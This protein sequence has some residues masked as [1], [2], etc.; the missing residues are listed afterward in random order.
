MELKLKDG[1][2][3]Y[4]FS[5]VFAGL[6][7]EILGLSLIVP[8]S[9]DTARLISGVFLALGS[10]IAFIWGCEVKKEPQS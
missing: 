8:E 5:G 3:H 10:V 6:F 2:W 1:W 7:V 4:F 9:V